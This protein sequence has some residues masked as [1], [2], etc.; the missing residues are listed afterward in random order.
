M[1]EPLTR[2]PH[3]RLIVAP[4]VSRSDLAR[5]ERSSKAIFSAAATEVIM[6]PHNCPRR[7]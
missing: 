3:I 2:L 4:G 1:R 7:G 6:S 5:R